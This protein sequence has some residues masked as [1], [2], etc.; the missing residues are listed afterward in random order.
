[1]KKYN[2]EHDLFRTLKSKNSNELYYVILS[3]VN[4]TY[5]YEIK[6]LNRV[7]YEELMV[8]LEKFIVIGS[9]STNFDTLEDIIDAILKF[10]NNL[11]KLNFRKIRK[12]TML[13]IS[14]SFKLKLAKL[15]R[16]SLLLKISSLTLAAIIFVSMYSKNLQAIDYEDYS[17]NINIEIE[18]NYELETNKEEIIAFNNEIEESE[19]F[20]E[21]PVEVTTEEKINVILDKFNLTNEQFDVVCAI[22]MTEAKPDSYD[23]AYAV[24]NTIYNR[25]ITNSWI[26]EINKLHTEDVG[27]SLY[28]QAIHPNQFV[29]YQEGYYLRNLNVREGNTFQAVIDFLYNLEIKHNYLSFRSADTELDFFYEQ[30]TINGNKYFNLIRD[31]DRVIQNEDI[32]SNNR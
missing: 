30:F 29:V 12:N 17:D 2:I 26:E 15:K 28:F 1:M 9:R 24:I 18:H 31:E 27:R 6:Y 7:P 3:M 19:H 10:S 25:T 4:N 14:Y 22:T 21:L 8:Y 20:E 13:N 11:E 23:D 16:H 5:R 32:N